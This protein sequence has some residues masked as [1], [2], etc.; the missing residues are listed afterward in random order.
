MKGHSGPFII[1][2]FLFLSFQALLGMGTLSFHLPSICK[3]YFTVDIQN[4]FHGTDRFMLYL[5][6]AFMDAYMHA[7]REVSLCQM[8]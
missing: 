1:L 4:H 3:K 7:L 5:R 2:L 6:Q 8:L